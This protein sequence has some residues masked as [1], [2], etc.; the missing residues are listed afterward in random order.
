MLKFDKIHSIDCLRAYTSTMIGIGA[1]CLQGC[2]ANRETNA[3]VSTSYLIRFMGVDRKININNQLSHQ[4]C[5]V[6]DNTE[7]NANMDRWC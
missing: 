2:R 7:H 6:T 1:I 3:S 4:V 5:K